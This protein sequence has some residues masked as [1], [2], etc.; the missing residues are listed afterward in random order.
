LNAPIEE[1]IISS[2]LVHL[3]NASYRLGRAIRFDPETEQ[4]IDDDDDEA[5]HLLRDAGV[6]IGSRLFCRGKFYG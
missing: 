4:A 5:N 6:D 2:A 3:A 1:G